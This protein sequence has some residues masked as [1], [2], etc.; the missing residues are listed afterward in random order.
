[1]RAAT[2]R[3]DERH[4]PYPRERPKIEIGKGADKQ[5]D[6]RRGEQPFIKSRR[7]RAQ[8]TR[9]PQASG[10]STAPLKRKGILHGCEFNKELLALPFSLA[11]SDKADEEEKEKLFFTIVALDG[12]YAKS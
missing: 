8:Q 12:H 1:M 9:Q 7:A 10:A 11:E 4:E 5:H 3:E 6:G 2:H